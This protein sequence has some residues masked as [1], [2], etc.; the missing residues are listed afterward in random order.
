MTV[1]PKKLW[2]AQHGR[3]FHCDGI[4]SPWSAPNHKE[5]DIGWTREHFVPRKHLRGKVKPKFNI[6]LAHAG[7]N[8][9]RGS[10]FPTE[11][12]VIKFKTI[13]MELFDNSG[14]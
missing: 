9:K 8:L 11:K 10:R 12:E 14:V 7:C 6:V 5:N 1:T 2:H 4:M 3:C 13:H